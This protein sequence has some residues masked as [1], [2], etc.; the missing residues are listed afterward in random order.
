MADVTTT[1]NEDR[2][3]RRASL[4]FRRLN[5]ALA[6][7]G[8]D[9]ET[10]PANNRE[11]HA[12]AERNLAR[13]RSI[14]NELAKRV[15][16]T[17][18]TRERVRHAI[19]EPREIEIAPG[20]AKAHKFDWAL[21][22]IRDRLQGRR[23][24]AAERLRDAYEAS[25]PVSRVADPTAIGGAADPSKRLAITEAQ[26]IAGRDLAW[27]MGR[28]DQPFRSCIKNFV[29]EQVREGA[30]RCLTISEWGSKGTGYSGD[31]ARAAG[32]QAIADALARLVTLWNAYDQ[33]RGERCTKT[34]RLLCSEIGRRAARDGW[35]VALWDFCHRYGRQPATQGE[36]DECRA[37]HD[38]EAT[39]LRSAPPIEMDR[40]LRR[41]DRLVSVAFRGFEDARVRV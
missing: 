2:E 20:Q 36:V 38:A 37:A 21:D 24:E 26:E 6:R 17:A 33:D 1:T 30:E 15:A 32:V 29:L 40:W 12:L 35:I 39:R 41:R 22:E 23:Y 8:I 14:E 31:M 13:V 25:Q 9:L 28:L 11:S 5:R 3:R 7:L 16:P 27:I 18:P 4:A 34:D 19:V 10:V